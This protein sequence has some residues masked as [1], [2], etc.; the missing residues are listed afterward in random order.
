ML[1]KDQPPASVQQ[2]SVRARLAAPPRRARVTA[3][4]QEDAEPFALFPLHHRIVGDVGEEQA[5]VL[6]DPDGPFRPLEPFGQLPQN[7]IA[8]NELVEAGVQPLDGPD[9]RIDFL[10]LLSHRRT[11]PTRDHRR[12]YRRYHH[13]DQ[14]NTCAKQDR[15]SHGSGPRQADFGDNGRIAA[16]RQTRLPGHATLSQCGVQATRSRGQNSWRPPK[17]ASTPGGVDNRPTR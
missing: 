8:R 11:P 7:R 16:A 15:S 2:Q 6:A 5:A 1:T 9:L 13:R 3:G 10:R 17:A 14:Q 4:L 12:D